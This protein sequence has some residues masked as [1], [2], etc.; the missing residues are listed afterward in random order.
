M[1][2]FLARLPLVYIFQSLFVLR[3]C[4]NGSVFNN[5]NLLLTAKLLKQVYQYHKIRKAFSKFY[6]RHSELIV[7]YNN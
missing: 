2:M 6:L 5:R 3:V 7:K 4:S 1:E